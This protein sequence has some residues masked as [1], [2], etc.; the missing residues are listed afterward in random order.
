MCFSPQ[1]DLVSG[2]V[3]GAIG[4]DCLRHVRHRRSDHLAFA[5]LP[6]LFGV[7]QLTEALVWWGLRGDLPAGWTQPATWAYLLFAFVVLPVYVPAAIRALEPRGVRRNVM[8][9]FVGIGA[10]VSLVLLVA[11][12][13]GPV[14]ARLADHHIAYSTNESAG[15][16]ITVAYVGATCGSA[17]F[18]GYRHIAAFG[19]LNLVA[20]GVIAYLTVDGFA[21]VWC[22]WAAITSIAIAWHLRRTSETR[23]VAEAL[24]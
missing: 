17:L 1:A 24:T 11:M 22:G 12:I 10:A 21:S 8:A 7:H 9:A 20:V 2:V 16:L 19:V 15:V 23:S 3:I 13:R 5:A 6:L 18:A 4:I 14:T